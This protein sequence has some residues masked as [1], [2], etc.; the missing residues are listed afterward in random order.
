MTVEKTPIEKTLVKKPI[1]VEDLDTLRG[2]E[3]T[4]SESGDKRDTFQPEFEV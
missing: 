1:K 3:I 2:G 4:T